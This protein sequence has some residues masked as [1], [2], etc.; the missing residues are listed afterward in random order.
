MECQGGSYLASDLGTGL[1]PTACVTTNHTA[2]WS[3]FT[4]N[5]PSVHVL[6]F[7]FPILTF[8]QEL[9]D[10]VITY[11]RLYMCYCLPSYKLILLPAQS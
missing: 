5:V 9:Q 3:L 10:L 8:I 7:T 4:Y 1:G 6:L 11:N 2:V